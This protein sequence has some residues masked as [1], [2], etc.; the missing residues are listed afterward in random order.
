MSARLFA[1]IA[2]GADAAILVT[3]VGIFLERLAA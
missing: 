2:L 1:S 3:L